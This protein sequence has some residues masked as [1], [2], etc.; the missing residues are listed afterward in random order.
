MLR[1]LFAGFLFI[2]VPDNNNNNTPGNPKHGNNQP[3][4]HDNNNTQQQQ[5]NNRGVEHAS[6]RQESKNWL[7]MQTLAL[8]KDSRFYGRQRSQEP[9][10][11]QK[12]RT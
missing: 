1:N 4:I 7:Q 2:F 10:K 6:I 5:H 9:N 3:D 12:D 8:Q 11:L